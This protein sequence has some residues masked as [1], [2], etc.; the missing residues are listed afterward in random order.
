MLSH[1]L[2]RL[3]HGRVLPQRIL[4]LWV[5]RQLS[6]ALGVMLRVD[7]EAVDEVRDEG[8]VGQEERLVRVCRS[9]GGSVLLRVCQALCLI[10]VHT[11]CAATH[12]RC[13]A[14]GP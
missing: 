8:G 4:G 2:Q 9:T 3:A 10:L 1:R 11:V 13:R 6:Q 5:Q 14:R 7:E 12:R